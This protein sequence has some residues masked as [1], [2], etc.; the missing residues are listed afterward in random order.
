[1]YRDVRVVDRFKCW[2]SNGIELFETWSKYSGGGQ[3]LEQSNVE[4]SIFRN[5]EVLNIKRTKT[6]DSIFF[7]FEF[8]FY[9]YICLHYSNTQNLWW[10]IKLEIYRTLEFKLEVFGTCRIRNF[11]SFPNC[12]LWNFPSWTF[13]WFSKF[14]IF[15]IFQIN[16][17]WNFRNWIFLKFFKL[18]IF[19]IFEIANL[20][21]L[22][23]RQFLEFSKFGKLTNF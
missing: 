13:L 14:Q 6:W 16:N 10:F 17:F 7:I 12:K 19:W 15:G 23:N 2:A 5:L 8:I 20:S 3:H 4:R 18:E 11:S 1:M 22:P 21:N 9:F